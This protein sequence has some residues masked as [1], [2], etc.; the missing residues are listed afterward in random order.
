M[1]DVHEYRYAG[2]FVVDAR[3]AGLVAFIALCVSVLVLAL[4]FRGRRWHEYVAGFITIYAGVVLLFV[5]FCNY[6]LRFPVFVV[7]SFFKF[8]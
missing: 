4:L 1:N 8:P 6:V 3:L 2:W 5:G 7:E